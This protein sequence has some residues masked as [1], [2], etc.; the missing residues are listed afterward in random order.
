MY[1]CSFKGMKRKTTF[2]RRD[3]FERSVIVMGLTI[4]YV[5]IHVISDKL[6]FFDFWITTFLR[7]LIFM[8]FIMVD[9]SKWRI[10]CKFW[11]FLLQI[12]P[13]SPSIIHLD[14][15]K[16]IFFSQFLKNEIEISE[17]MI[18]CHFESFSPS[19]SHLD[20][21]NSKTDF[22]LI[23]QVWYLRSFA[24]SCSGMRTIYH[25]NTLI[26]CIQMW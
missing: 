21:W 11:C 15:W 4:W 16:S 22:F 3:K 25:I 17:L 10:H 19:I 1:K 18:F 24:F 14:G 2:S 23:N 26:F 6:M 7:Y 20:G 8:T 9:K 12:I 13:F 5:I